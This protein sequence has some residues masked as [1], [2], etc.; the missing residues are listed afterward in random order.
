MGPEAQERMLGAIHEL[1]GPLSIVNGYLA[2]MQD[3]SMGEVGREV[4]EVLPLLRAKMREMNG[5]VDEVLETA[6]GQDT[7][8]QLH[9]SRLDLREV[10]RDAVRSLEPLLDERH[11]L[12]VSTSGGPVPVRGDRDRL[13]VVITNLVHNAIKYSPAGGEVRVD[14]HVREDKALVSVSDQGLGIS[15]ED[16]ARLFTRFSR[17]ATP[18]SENIPGTGLG[19]YLARDVARRHGGDVTVESR[20]GLGSTFSLTLPLN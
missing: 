11:H 9:L 19:L 6:R 16:Q 12:T 18:G 10:V 5:L 8:L 7:P 4:A 3:G 14:C 15:T 2:M 20:L 13:R 1:R 17:I